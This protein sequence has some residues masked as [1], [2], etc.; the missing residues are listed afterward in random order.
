M[1]IITQTRRGNN[2]ENEQDITEPTYGNRLEIEDLRSEYIGAIQR[3][4]GYSSLYN[5]HG[6]TF[7]S[8]RTGI[9]KLIEVNKILEEDN[10]CEVPL[11]EVLPGDVVLYY[12]ISGD[13]EHS[14]IVIENKN[15][16]GI[17]IPKILS[18]WGISFEMIHLVQNCPYYVGNIIKYYRNA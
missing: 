18:K 3:S 14:G 2:I 4:N 1:A 11:T 16:S 15:H 10:Y 9:Y 13:I 5:C 8:R 17:R 7:A 6:M 12:S